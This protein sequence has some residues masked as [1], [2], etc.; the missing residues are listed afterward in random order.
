MKLST[1]LVAS[2]LLVL[3]GANM[4][5]E[6]MLTDNEL[7]HKL[8]KRGLPLPPGLP[9]WC[10]NEGQNCWD[11]RCCSGL[12]CVDLICKSCTPRKCKTT[13]DCCD[14]SSCINGNCKSCN[15]RKCKMN[16]DCCNDSRCVYGNCKSCKQRTCKRSNDCCKGY[17]CSYKK[18]VQSK[19][20]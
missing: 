9:S 12:S 20:D 1:Y 4:A 8:V 18:C 2:L 15:L 17:N 19:K 13:R 5:N 16:H 3:V 11:F 6:E 14:D 7:V 10:K